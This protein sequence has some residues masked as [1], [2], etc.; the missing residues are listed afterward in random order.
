MAMK[1]FRTVAWRHWS[2]ALW[3]EGNGRFAS[4]AACPPGHTVMLFEQKTDAEEAKKA[5]D[6]TGCSSGC[7]GRH[8]V[9]DLS[10]SQKPLP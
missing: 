8:S 1:R 5:I 10:V 2:H 4:V 7:C 3:I 9:V 6:D